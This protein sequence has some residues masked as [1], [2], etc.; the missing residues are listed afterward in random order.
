MQSR[1][2]CRIDRHARGFR[3]SDLGS[4]NGT[5]VNGK[6]ITTHELQTGDVIK[7]GATLLQFQGISA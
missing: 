3:I 2:T 6:R 7:I 4:S 1:A 5:Y